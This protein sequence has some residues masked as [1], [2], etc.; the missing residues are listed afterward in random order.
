[1]DIVP[2]LLHGA[3]HV[4]PK[5]DFMLRKGSIT[6]QVHPRITYGDTRYGNGY[7]A[8]TKQIRHYYQ[9]IY[10][11][12]AQKNETAGYF[13]NF[14]LQNYLYKGVNIERSVRKTLKKTNC[15]SQW[16]DTGKNTGIVLVINAGYGEFGF[17]YALVHRQVQVISVEQDEDKAALAQSCTG[18][19][20]NLTIYKE[21]D[22]P[23]GIKFD[24][25]YLLNPGETQKEKYN[26]YGAQVIE[27]V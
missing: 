9:Q 27:I 1:L 23:A 6:V 21:P 4:L 19:P 2:V 11:S 24:S 25:I 10:A 8:Q 15:F 16:I 26:N 22:F 12:I 7:V 20:G 13:K 14:V 18:I 17:L 5:E 3:G